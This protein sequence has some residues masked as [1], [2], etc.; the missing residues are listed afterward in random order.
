[1]PPSNNVITSFL[2]TL[3]GQSHFGA[4]GRPIPYVGG[5]AGHETIVGG[6]DY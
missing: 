1:M 5:A 3:I 2:S 6:V 4:E